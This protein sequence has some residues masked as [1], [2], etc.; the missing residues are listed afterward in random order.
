MRKVCD[1]H[2]LLRLGVSRSGNL[3]GSD[4]FPG[5]LRYFV[6]YWGVAYDENRVR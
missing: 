2:P 5:K 6:V 4:T 1:L 3:A